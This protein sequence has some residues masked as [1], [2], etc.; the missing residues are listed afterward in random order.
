VVV[1]PSH[2][3]TRIAVL[4]MQNSP[5]GTLRAEYTTLAKTSQARL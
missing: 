2:G 5:D 1:E 4:T 3:E